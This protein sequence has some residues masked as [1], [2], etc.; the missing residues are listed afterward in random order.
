MQ[1]VA[2]AV[3]A[4]ALVSVGL[5]AVNGSM[6]YEPEL[7]ISTDPGVGNFVLTEDFWA[8]FAV[9]FPAATG[10]M[11]GANM[12]G[13]LKDPRQSIPLGTMAAIAVSYVIYVALAYRL[14]A[15]A[16]PAEL[17]DNYTIMIDKAFWGPAV[18]G[19]LLGATFS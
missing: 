5:A 2:A 8:V 13:E 18:L 15:S 11:A 6:Q 10:I 1:Y 12:S 14:A 7:F 19:G 16:S 4:A 9:F 17:R 3:I